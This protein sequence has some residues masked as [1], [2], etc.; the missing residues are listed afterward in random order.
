MPLLQ[1]KNLHHSF[2]DRPLLDGVD[3]ALERETQSMADCQRRRSVAGVVRPE[4]RKVHLDRVMRHLDEK[5]IIGYEA[6]NRPAWLSIPIKGVASLLA[7][8]EQADDTS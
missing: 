6:A 2:G 4:Q 8:G 5:E 7:Q 1:A 3:H